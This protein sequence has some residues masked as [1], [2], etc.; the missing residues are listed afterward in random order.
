MAGGGGGGYHREGGHG[1]VRGVGGVRGVGRVL[2]RYHVM[3]LGIRASKLHTQVRNP[4]EGL[5]EGLLLVESTFTF[6]TQSRH[7][8][9]Q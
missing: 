4:G 5:Y 1:V 9:K 3:T 2:H 8:A 7:Y 6:K